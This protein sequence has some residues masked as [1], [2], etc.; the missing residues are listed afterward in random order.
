L[1]KLNMW[2]GF[3]NAMCVHQRTVNNRSFYETPM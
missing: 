3:Y 1:N 2:T